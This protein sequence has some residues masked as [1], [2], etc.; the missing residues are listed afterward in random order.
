ML[1][2]FGNKLHHSHISVY[3]MGF[4]YGK[5]SPINKTNVIQLSYASCRLTG[6]QAALPSLLRIRIRDYY[7]APTDHK[8]LAF[9]Y[10]KLYLCS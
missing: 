5:N 1:H 10:F 8:I 6:I 3:V 2:N 4:I 7:E 9:T